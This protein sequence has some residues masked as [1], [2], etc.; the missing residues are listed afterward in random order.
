MQKIGLIVLVTLLMAGCEGTNW[1]SSVPD[2][3]IHFEI[4]T[5]AGMF[6]NF[7]P[8]N[9]T[10]YLIVDQAGYHLNG[11][12]QPL[13]VTDAYGYA[14]TVVYIDG[15]HPYAAYDLCCPHC[16]NRDKPCQVDGLFAVCPECG[17]HYDIYSGNG[18]PTRG[19]AVEPLKQYNASYSEGTGKLFVSHK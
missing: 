15:Y 3:P 13:L 2:F 10:S 8:A 4:N 1:K 11:V 16:V 9:V 12:T 18:V 14:G 6:V 5:N 19:I 17:E 7:V